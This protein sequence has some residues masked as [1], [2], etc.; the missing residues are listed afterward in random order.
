[1]NKRMISLLVYIT[2]TFLYSCEPVIEYV[3]VEK[4]VE[5]ERIVT[6]TVEVEV[7]KEVSEI[8]S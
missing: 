5:T 8:R 3:E 7:E 2:M 4:I 6:E 1:M